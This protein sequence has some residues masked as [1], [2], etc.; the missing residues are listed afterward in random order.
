MGSP[1]EECESP[2]TNADR[3]LLSQAS[4]SDTELCHISSHL[5]IERF[6]T[7]ALSFFGGGVGGQ[8]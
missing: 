4:G 1:G 6:D 8:P 2:L 3:R 5:P 7:N